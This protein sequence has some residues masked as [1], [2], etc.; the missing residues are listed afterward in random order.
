LKGSEKPQALNLILGLQKT[1]QQN[2]SSNINLESVMFHNPSR[3]V[4]FSRSSQGRAVQARQRFRPKVRLG[5]K[6]VLL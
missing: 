1:E 2:H 6:K 3:H 4:R 5:T